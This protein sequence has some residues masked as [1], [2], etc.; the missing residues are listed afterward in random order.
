MSSPQWKTALEFVRLQIK[1]IQDEINANETETV[2]LLATSMENSLHRET[3]S[4]LIGHGILEGR[5]MVYK[6][7]EGFFASLDQDPVDDRTN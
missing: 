5:K 2:T 4:K 3:V 1:E 7:M 6:D